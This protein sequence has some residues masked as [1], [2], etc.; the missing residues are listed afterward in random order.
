LCNVG[1]EIQRG[2][3]IPDGFVCGGVGGGDTRANH[4]YLVC[5]SYIHIAGVFVDW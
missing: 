2:I 5:E 3:A 1:G 4:V